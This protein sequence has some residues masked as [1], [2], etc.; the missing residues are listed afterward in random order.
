MTR[1]KLDA[2]RDA[3]PSVLPSMLMCD[4]GDLKTEI[5]KLS[6]AGS[7]ILHLDVMDGNFVPNLSYGMPIV[8][9]LR[10]YTNMPLDVHLMI[11]DPLKYAAP[12]VDAGADMLTFHV[13]AV[14]DAAFTA[15]QIRKLGAGVGVAL[16]PA[17]PITDLEACLEH[18]DMV[19]VMSVDAGF[20]GQSFNPIALEKLKL[21]RANHS[22]LLLQIDGGINTETISEARRAGCDLFVVGSGI[23]RA[24]DYG[25]AIRELDGLIAAADAQK[26]AGA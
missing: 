4:F 6:S 23:F 19:L 8:A 12:M 18:V 10:R 17:T 25:V 5:A 16:N 15:K 13:E 20:G 1:A 2:I 11:A 22:D 21:L 3:A 9:G 26:G 24:E 14:E 7:K